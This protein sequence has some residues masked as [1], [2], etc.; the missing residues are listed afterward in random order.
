VREHGPALELE[1]P[2]A[3]R[4][5]D[6][7]GPDHVRRHEVR[8]ELDARERQ[9]QG[10]GQRLDEEGLAQAG[11]ALEQHVAARE[12]RGDDPPDDRRLPDQ[13]PPDLRRQPVEV[14]AELG[15][16]GGDVALF[17]R[18]GGSGG[19]YGHGLLAVRGRMSWKYRRTT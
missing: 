1:A 4:L 2:L 7:V 9:V 12:Q 5:D 6:H 19:L 8:R 18:L 14:G 13:A 15:D 17:G 10:L 11:H 3:A 16:D